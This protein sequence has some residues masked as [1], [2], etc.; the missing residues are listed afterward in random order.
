MLLSCC[1]YVMFIYS[2]TCIYYQSHNEF[3]ITHGSALM[4]C[5]ILK[6]KNKKNNQPK[7]ESKIICLNRFLSS[8]TVLV[9]SCVLFSY[10]LNFKIGWR[11]IYPPKG[12]WENIRENKHLARD[13]YQRRTH[14]ANKALFILL[15]AKISPTIPHPIQRGQEKNKHSIMRG[16]I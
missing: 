3:L 16:M 1:L 13:A 10:Y 15:L 2:Y 12:K 7:K 9:V 5:S 4:L 11:V 6:K 14:R 8:F